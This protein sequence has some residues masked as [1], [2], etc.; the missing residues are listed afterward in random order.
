MVAQGKRG[1]LGGGPLQR[2]MSSNQGPPVVNTISPNYTHISSGLYVV[3]TGEKLTNTVS[4]KFGTIAA[5]WFTVIDDT[6]IHCMP[7]PVAAS[8]SVNIIVTS[9]TG[10][11]ASFG[12]FAF[13]SSTVGSGLTYINS[14]DNPYGFAGGCIGPDSLPWWGATYGSVWKLQSGNAI[15]FPVS[16]GITSSG[17]TAPICAGPDGNI[18]ATDGEGY[19]WRIPLTGSGPTLANYELPGASLTPKPS[20]ICVGS[21]SRIWIPG[22]LGGLLWGINVQGTV[23]TYVISGRLPLGICQG[24]DSNLWLT[25]IGGAGRLLKVSNSGTLLNAYQVTSGA[26]L[27]TIGVGTDNKLYIADTGSSG[28]AIHKVDPAFPSSGQRFQ[29]TALSPGVIS[30]GPDGNIYMGGTA[31]ISGVGGGGGQGCI[32]RCTQSGSVSN[33][34]ITNLAVYS[35]ASLGFLAGAI[36]AQDGSMY[37]PFLQLTSGTSNPAG[38]PGFVVKMT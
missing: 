29:T 6:T 12:P 9:A 2:A 31:A 3:L 14:S 22:T 36:P 20:R 8:M 4:V 13:I 1:Y 21:D 27:V 38:Y 18:W 15:Q 16:S 37:F 24:P 7:F 28:V 17:E 26:T 30:P 10:L 33:T 32:F 23:S 5:Q 25:D 35:G 34:F 19:V 11:T